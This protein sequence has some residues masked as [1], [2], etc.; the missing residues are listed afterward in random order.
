MSPTADGAGGETRNLLRECG[1][2]IVRTFP[3]HVPV[4]LCAFV[5]GAAT[6]AI[7]ALFRVPLELD[8]GEFFLGVV[9]KFFA[10]G[11]G[12]AALW[13]LASL[14]RAGFPI[15]PAQTIVI[16]IHARFFSGERLGNVF[17]TLVAFTPLM[18]SFAALKGVIPQVHPFAWDSTFMHWDR[19]MGLGHMPWQVLQPLLGHPPVT[20]LINLIYDSWFIVMFGGFFWQAFSAKGGELRLQFLLAFSFAWFIA[21]N[22]LAAIF[23]SAGP[24]FYGLLLP[25]GPD[26]YGAQMAYLH[27]TALHWPVWSVTL[28]DLL[29]HSYVRG[30]GNLGGISAM[31]SMH[32]T[33][34]AVLALVAWR[35]DRRLGIA[36]WSYT[37]LI[38]LGSVHLAWHYV[39][40]GIAGLLLAFLFWITAGALARASLRALNP[41]GFTAIR[42]PA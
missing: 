39:S 2:S 31:P 28:Q 5:F 36:M 17:H 40:D 23:S 22:I 16:R 38:V 30:D 32:I 8:A 37:A 14:S 26:P 18:V 19:A 10:L 24:C 6:L 7:V 15:S 21:G 13:E 35:T 25:H 27:A 9:C 4:Y 33:S 29:W 41:A 12:L 34:S 11:A 42:E 20:A 1:L 3:E